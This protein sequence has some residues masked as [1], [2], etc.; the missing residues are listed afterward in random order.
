VS[1]H[2]HWELEGGGHGAVRAP[3]IS[4]TAGWRRTSE[5]NPRRHGASLRRW[6]A[7]PGANSF[8]LF[9]S[10]FSSVHEG[11]RVGG[12]PADSALQPARRAAGPAA[13]PSSPAF[14]HGS[15]S[16]QVSLAGSHGRLSW[17]PISP[18]LIASPPRLFGWR[19]GQAMEWPVRERRDGR[20]SQDDP[21]GLRN[22]VRISHRDQRGPSATGTGAARDSEI[23]SP[24]KD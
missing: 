5:S 4:A 11:V 10:V 3:L 8:W 16:W 18:A 20:P 23:R 13:R 21:D 9:F 2:W 15:F 19:A 17:Q 1:S 6:P 12:W 14:L 7:H 22:Q 24:R